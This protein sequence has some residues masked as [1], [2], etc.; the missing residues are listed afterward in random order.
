MTNVRSAPASIGIPGATVNAL[1]EMDGPDPISVVQPLPSGVV[2]ATMQEAMTFTST[3]PSHGRLDLKF[4]EKFPSAFKKRIE[5]LSA[6]LDATHQ[7]VPGTVYCTESG[8]TPEFSA[9]TAGAVGSA[10]TGTRLLAKLDSLPHAVSLLIVPNEVSASSGPLVAHRV[11]PPF[12]ADFVGGSIP[13]IG[14]VSLVGVSGHSAELL[15]EV[16]ANSP[17]H[18]VTGCNVI[19]T[20]DI[21]VSSFPAVPLGAA[22][23][24]GHLVPTDPDPFATP[25]PTSPRPRF[26]P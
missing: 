6:P 10:D 1:I 21:N 3:A 4:E 23:V 11:F 26:K 7:D 2:I 22:V 8:F 12:A 20:F 13:I 16:T 17:F 18:G 9:V 14:G 19:D 15:Y 25:S 24:T 5:N